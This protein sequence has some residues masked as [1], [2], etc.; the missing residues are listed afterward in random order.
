M[1]LLCDEKLDFLSHEDD[2]KYKPQYITF[3]EIQIMNIKSLSE[4]NKVIISIG[5]Q[6][7][8]RIANKI[9]LYDIIRLLDDTHTPSLIPTNVCDWAYTASVLCLDESMFV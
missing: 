2:E 4:L 6:N 3:K 8:A 1:S 5:K 7:T 9:L